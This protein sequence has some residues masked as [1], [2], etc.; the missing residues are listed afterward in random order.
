MRGEKSKRIRDEIKKIISLKE[1]N[2]FIQNNLN[3]DLNIIRNFYASIGYNF[4]DIKVKRKE[5]DNDNLD[6]VFEIER[7]EITKIS[8]IS[9]F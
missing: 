9:F 8:K 2:S 5:I 7:G 6:L 1:N 3:N 4:A